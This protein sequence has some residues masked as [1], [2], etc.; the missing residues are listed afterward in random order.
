M[1]KN[2]PHPFV[3]TPNNGPCSSCGKSRTN[4]IHNYTEPRGVVKDAVTG[5]LEVTG[6]TQAATVTVKI[7]RSSGPC[8]DLVVESEF[9]LAQVDLIEDVIAMVNKA[10]GG[11]EEWYLVVGDDNTHRIPRV[12]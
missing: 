12:N 5:N 11:R 2:W 3:S 9:E 1:K 10:T 7:S 8:T 6:N 4:K